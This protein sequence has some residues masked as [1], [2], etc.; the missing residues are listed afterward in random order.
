MIYSA[1]TYAKD[2]TL[3]PLFVDGKSMYSRYSPQKEAEKYANITEK[4]KAFF[5]VTG[6]GNGLHIRSLL[7][8][9]PDSYFFV[10]ENSLEDYQWLKNH[11]DIEDI[12]FHPHIHITFLDYFIP[13][14]KQTYI[15]QLHGDFVYAPLRSWLDQIQKHECNFSKKLEEYISELTSDMATQAH[16]GKQWFSNFFTNL[17]CIFDEQTT[18]KTI[19]SKV[20]ITAAGPSLEQFLPQIQ[21]KRQNNDYFIIATDTSVPVLRK[22]GIHPDVAVCIDS[23]I[24]SKNHFFI[25]SSS[26]EHLKNTIFAFDLCVSP[27]VVATVRAKGNA[28]FFFRNNNPLSTLFSRF[29]T[30]NADQEI[31]LLNT[32]GGTVT[33]AAFDLARHLGFTDIEVFGA[34]FA[35]INGKPYCKGT[36]FEDLFSVSCDRL[37][38]LDKKYTDLLYRLPTTQLQ[39]QS[40]TTDILQKYK[41][42]FYEYIGACTNTTCQVQGMTIQ[43]N[44]TTNHSSQRTPT[45]YKYLT[46]TIIKKHVQNFIRFYTKELKRLSSLT[47]TFFDENIV[48]IKDLL[49]ISEII[50]SLLPLFSWDIKK[51]NTEKSFLRIIKLAHSYM[52]RYTDTL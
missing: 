33:S 24:H 23:Q 6:F 22:W 9:Y 52:I 47:D 30:Q 26:K 18:I 40:I 46:S 45:E 50:P 13:E 44:N 4:S 29:I 51:N 49:T 19:A 15:P 43:N 35:Y 21:A 48:S 25:D 11:F 28:I 27:S 42:S 5:L 8:K 34:D 10:V 39:N 7:K 1:V 31:P 37:S 36:Y 2:T 3:I 32:G 17:T 20:I 16:F 38:P 12:I 14:L 41:K